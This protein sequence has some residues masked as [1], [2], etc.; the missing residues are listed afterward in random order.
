[1]KTRWFMIFTI[2]AKKKQKNKNTHTQKKHSSDLREKYRK[3][4]IIRVFFLSKIINTYEI[5]KFKPK[6]KHRKVKTFHPSY[7]GN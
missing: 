4:P 3:K 7:Q 5:D 6:R 1:M 2:H